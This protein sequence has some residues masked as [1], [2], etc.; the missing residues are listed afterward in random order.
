MGYHEGELAMQERAGVRDLAARVA[1]IIGTDVPAAAAG[2]MAAQRFVFVGASR[3]DGTLSASILGGPAGFTRASNPTTI[4]VR[5]A[6]GDVDAVRANVAETTMFAMLAIDFALRRR[7]RLNGTATLSDDAIVVSTREVYANCPQFIVPRAAT[8]VARAG[9]ATRVTHS[10]DE[11][12]Q[13]FVARARTFIIASAHHQRGADIS[14]RGGEAG[15]IHVEHDCL[16]WPDYDGNN[17][18]N[19]LG[20]L[21]VNPRSALLFVDFDLG[22]TLQLRGDATVIGADRRE[23]RF[24]ITEVLDT[25]HAIP[26]QFH[27]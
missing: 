26:L 17:M 9:A 19:T 3:D 25:K 5:P 6:W 21:L 14:H 24:R 2:F 15:F 8:A 7:I 18:F 13:S 12:Q 23:V 16:T 4:I 20:N 22:S 11:A 10:L 1:R 27:E